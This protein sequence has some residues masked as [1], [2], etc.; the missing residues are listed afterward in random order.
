MALMLLLKYPAPG[1][2]NGP[3]TFVNDAIYLRDNFSAAGGAEIISKYG[4]KPPS[5]SSL[6]SQPSTP[7]SMPMSPRD[8]L[9]RQKSPLPSPVRFLQQQGGVEGLFRGAAKGVFERGERLGINQAVRDAVGEV[10]Q[11]MQGLQVS[12]TNS[13]RHEGTR[14]SLDE[15][16][17]VPSS[18]T[19]ISAMNMR[20]KQLARM[21][22]QAMTE[23]RKVSVSKE[24]NTEKYS[25][26]M[27]IAIAKV[28]FVKIYLEDAT[29]P[30]PPDSPELHPSIS[31]HEIQE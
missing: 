5:V 12:R 14:W 3:R 13:V 9:R 27:D 16:K 21:L 1:R 10:R 11:N 8:M 4:A 29:M 6:D 18:R 31:G 20:N 19:S 7:L 30:L 28:D 23:L 17:S 25:E 22:D 26:A 24:V 2:P 15:G